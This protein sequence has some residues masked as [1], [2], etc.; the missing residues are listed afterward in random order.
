MGIMGI[1]EDVNTIFIKSEA[2]KIK[3]KIGGKDKIETPIKEIRNSFF[4]L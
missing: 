4:T 3:T 2:I 1:H